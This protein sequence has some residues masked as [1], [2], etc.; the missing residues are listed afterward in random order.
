MVYHTTILLQFTLKAQW[1]IVMDILA[2][3]DNR[4]SLLVNNSCMSSIDM[5]TFLS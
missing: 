2:L 3:L 4:N 5:I 1:Y